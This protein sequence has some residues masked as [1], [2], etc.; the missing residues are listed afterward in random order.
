MQQPV[1]NNLII[2]FHGTITDHVTR[3]QESIRYACTDLGISGADAERVIRSCFAS[4]TEGDRF[5][6]LILG[7]Y[8]TLFAGIPG[9][10]LTTAEKFI[11]LTRAY[12][13][14]LYFPAAGL[15]ESF[16]QLYALGTNIMVLTNGSS[17]GAGSYTDKIFE[18]FTSWG[19]L[20]PVTLQDS[21]FNPILEQEMINKRLIILSTVDDMK[22]TGGDL[23]KG[24]DTLSYKLA[25]AV[26]SI[27]ITTLRGNDFR[28]EETLVVGDYAT[29]IHLAK[30]LG[31]NCAFMAK[32]R[33]AL[34]TGNPN[35][36]Y[37]DQAS[38]S[39]RLFCI[40]DIRELPFLVQYGEV[41]RTVKEVPGEQF[42]VSGT[43]QGRPL[44]NLLVDSLTL[45]TKGFESFSVRSNPEC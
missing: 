18:I 14:R 34:S 35:G 11:D 17:A 12:R 22:V 31:C 44:Y 3:F 4:R 21:H 42:L 1:I 2:D 30:A 19:L 43:N 6:D 26:S 36:K 37:Q 20:D 15:N 39:T 40:S 7:S 25:D 10:G 9:F 13:D 5:R 33:D 16:N 41:D 27:F 28:P 24:D 32:G 8:Q 23:R 45:R 29:D 38:D